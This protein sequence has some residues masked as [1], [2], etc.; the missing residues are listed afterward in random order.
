[1]PNSKN[2]DH[3]NHNGLDNRRCNL[4]SVT[5]MENLSNLRNQGKSKYVGVF[6]DRG[7]WRSR[8]QIRD[9]VYYLGSF[10]TEE[11]ASNAY[12]NKLKEVVI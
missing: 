8:L 3:I 9:K 11:E 7:R 4:R 5:T 12:Q 1:M 2:V 6:N 10:K